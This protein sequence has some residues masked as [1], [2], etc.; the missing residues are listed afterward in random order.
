MK[1]LHCSKE[2]INRRRQALYCS[3]RC[4]KQA[5]EQLGQRKPKEASERGDYGK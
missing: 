5:W 4:R 3:E 2:I 1:C